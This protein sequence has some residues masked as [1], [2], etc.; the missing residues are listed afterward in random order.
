MSLLVTGNYLQFL[1]GCILLWPG[2]VGS[3]DTSSKR[4]NCDATT[5]TTTLCFWA[6]AAGR[7]PGHID[8]T[9]SEISD[10][11]GVV[12]GSYS[13][14]DPRHKI[15]TVQYIADE[16]GFRSISNDPTPDLPS[17]TPVVAAAKERH[18]QRYA[19]IANAHQAGP[20]VFVPADTKAV[21]YAKNKHLSL[22]QKIA[23]EH[24][25]LAAEAEA[26]REGRRSYRCA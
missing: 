14:V 10:G 17:D 21:Q 23:E 26:V 25:R 2:A 6:H 4:R 15:R 16:N 12:Q 20:S 3:N 5:T 7:F 13:Y 24:A 11:S 9:H 8:R 18:L 22:Y 1:V 19:S